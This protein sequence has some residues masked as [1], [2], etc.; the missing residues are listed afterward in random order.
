MMIVSFLSCKFQGYANTYK[1]SDYVGRSNVCNLQVEVN[2]NGVLN[3]PEVSIINGDEL[4]YKDGNGLV[5]HQ[6]VIEDYFIDSEGTK[7]DGK[8]ARERV[9]NFFEGNGLKDSRTFEKTS[10][11]ISG[12]KTT[13]GNIDNRNADT[14]SH[15]S[16]TKSHGFTAKLSTSGE[17]DGVFVKS[18]LGFD[19]S[20]TWTTTVSYSIDI[21]P[22][23]AYKISVQ[24]SGTEYRWMI[25]KTEP[26]FQQ[27][28]SGSYQKWEGTKIVADRY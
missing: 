19:L 9:K 1:L 21:P 18:K 6:K 28:G 15:W 23:Q 27:I 25:F 22:K 11:D 24:P 16:Y 20:G 7:V 26:V 13:I 17:F 3:N 5:I 4:I 10:V 2:S 8:V 14:A 12:D